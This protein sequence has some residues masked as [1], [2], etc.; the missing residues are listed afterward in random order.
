MSMLTSGSWTSFWIRR[1]TGSGGG[2]TGWI[3]RGTRIPTGM[4]RTISAASGPIGTGGL[5]H[6]TGTCR[7][8]SLSQSGWPVVQWHRPEVAATQ[9]SKGG[10]T[11]LVDSEDG[12]VLV[13]GPVPSTDEYELEL[14]GIGADVTQLRLEVLADPALPGKGPG[15]QGGE[16]K[17]G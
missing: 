6:S 17:N 7:L 16:V 14:K 4:R 13:S 3:W 9:P 11:L 1:I 10:A 5:T 2:G 15:R 12:T 8:T